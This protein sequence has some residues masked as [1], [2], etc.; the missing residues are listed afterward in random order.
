MAFYS[1][2]SE[3]RNKIFEELLVLSQPITLDMCTDDSHDLYAVSPAPNL[4]TSASLSFCRTLLLVSKRMHSEASFLLYSRNRFRL[5][6]SVSTIGDEAQSA[7]LASFF[8]RIGRQKASFL[9]HICIAFPAFDNYRVVNVTLQEDSKRTLEL[10]RVNFV[11]IATIETSLETTHAM[12]VAIDTLDSP[13]AAA[14]MLA[15]VDARFKAIS[16]LKEVIVN[17]Y[18]EPPS[19]YL[20]KMIHDYGWTIKVTKLEVEESGVDGLF[21]EYDRAE[22]EYEAEHEYYAEMKKEEEMWLEEHYSRRRDPYWKNDSDY[23]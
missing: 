9:H 15:L 12:Q 19:D 7:I 8:D 5:K 6:D 3:I 16:S 23:D 21:D 2:P 22:A 18:D 17:V 10:I 11:N 14:E 1:L 4:N 13:R 20:R